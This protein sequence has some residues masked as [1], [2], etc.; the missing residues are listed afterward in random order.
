MVGFGV[1]VLLGAILA[2][3]PGLAPSLLHL[4]ECPT[5]DS[6]ACVWHADKHG[7]GLGQSFWVA[8]DGTV[9]YL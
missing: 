8:Q 4:A 1:K 7:N 3:A 9:H 6:V 5:E 2:V